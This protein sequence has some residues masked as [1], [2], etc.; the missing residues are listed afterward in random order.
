MRGSG[1]SAWFIAS[2]TI[3]VTSISLAPSD[4]RRVDSASE[5]CL[6]TEDRGFG[7]LIGASVCCSSDCDGS[8]AL[9]MRSVICV[10]SVSASDDGCE[11]L[12]SLLS[13]MGLARIRLTRIRLTD[14]TNKRCS[15]QDGH[16]LAFF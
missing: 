3:R 13:D 5:S 14:T 11:E 15:H 2:S 12:G 4:E 10:R 1:D 7:S 8:C 16:I 9:L 6:S